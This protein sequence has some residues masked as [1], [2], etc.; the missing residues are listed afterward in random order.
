MGVKLK[1]AL[2]LSVAI[3][4]MFSIQVND[5]ELPECFDKTMWDY[6][7]CNLKPKSLKNP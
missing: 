6:E 7:N 4:L 2:L 3:A 5:I 1:T